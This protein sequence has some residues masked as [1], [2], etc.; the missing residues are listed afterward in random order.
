MEREEA[1]S[2][3]VEE[4]KGRISP[5]LKK[6][7][8]QDYKQRGLSSLNEYVIE[9]LEHML[10]CDKVERIPRLRLI[11]LNFE[12]HCRMC[13][14]KLERGE[15]A[16]WAPGT[17]ICIDCQVLKYGDKAAV[18]LHMKKR[19]SKQLLKA[20]KNETEQMCQEIDEYSLLEK[21]NKAIDSS[22]ETD[23]LAKKYLTEA[24]GTS[25]EKEEFDDF[26]KSHRET[27]EAVAIVRELEERRV[28]RKE[29][30]K[31]VKAYA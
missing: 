31:G 15:R 18:A 24:I 25:R 23:K 28:K 14:K 1:E 29:K 4:I 9:A 19:E 13:H 20:F 22:L 5:K 17:V 7:I 11:P 6:A 12:D 21:G 16:W 27:R 2:E 26:V 8:E 3:M 30:K 10:T